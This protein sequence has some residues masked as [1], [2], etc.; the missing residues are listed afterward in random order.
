[1][2][3]FNFLSEKIADNAP[4]IKSSFFMLSFNLFS[5]RSLKTDSIKLASGSILISSANRSIDSPHLFESKKSLSVLCILKLSLF[6]IYMDE[7]P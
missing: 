5:V 4:S 6:I 1:M 3:V 7:L 2:F